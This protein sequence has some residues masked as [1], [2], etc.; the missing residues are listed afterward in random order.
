MSK[1]TTQEIYTNK[2]FKSNTLKNLYSECLTNKTTKSKAVE[3]FE[4][5]ICTDGAVVLLNYE[6]L[7]PNRAGRP[8]KNTNVEI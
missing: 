1:W 6:N 3:Y 7:N 8:K 4:F 5:K 2:S